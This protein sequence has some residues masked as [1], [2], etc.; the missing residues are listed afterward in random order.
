MTGRH[1]D[2]SSDDKITV[3]YQSILLSISDHIRLSAWKII[4]PFISYWSTPPPLPPSNIMILS[5]RLVLSQYNTPIILMHNWEGRLLCLLF[6]IRRI[7]YHWLAA[8]PVSGHSYYS[9]ICEGKGGIP[10][11][12][13]PRCYLA[14]VCLIMWLLFLSPHL[15]T[16]HHHA[17]TFIITSFVLSCALIRSATQ[18]HVME[19]YLG[20]SYHYTL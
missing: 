1:Y 20:I 11:S 12:S 9:I 16:I 4:N 3:S 14:L 15:S 18:K 6:L 2:V 19:N 10:G 8:V 17:T 7:C 13:H 5:C